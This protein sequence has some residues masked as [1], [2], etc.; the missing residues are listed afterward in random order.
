MEADA[1]DGEAAGALGP[2]VVAAIVGDESKRGGDSLALQAAEDIG[3][4]HAS[5]IETAPAPSW[6]RR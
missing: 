5:G 1:A 2:H 4:L 6:S 3:R